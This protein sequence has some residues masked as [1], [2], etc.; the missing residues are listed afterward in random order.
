[1]SDYDVRFK[2][3]VK[4]L[5]DL[6][7]KLRK[8]PGAVGRTLES[9]VKQEARGMAV[10]LARYTRPFGF[11]EKA[12]QRGEKSI[13]RDIYAVFATPAEAYESMTA[14]NGTRDKFWSEITTRKFAKARNT[15]A[16]SNSPMKGL[17]IGRLDPAI[18]RQHRTGPYANVARRRGVKAMIVTSAKSLDI[19]V[20]KVM[21]K[22]GFAKGSWINCAKAIGGRVRGSAQWVSRHKQSPGTAIVRTGD[23]TSVTLVNTLGYIDQVC[24]GEN[25]ERALD[26]AQNRLWRAISE[27]LKAINAKANR[28]ISRR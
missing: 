18:H 23:K 24:S 9:L 20:A 19:Y 25:V 21:K 26:E 27:S 8:H 11:S 10:E 2:V 4:G 14:D 28:T 5:P 3:D 12:K 15:L 13:C 17:A 1:M 7:L 6:A 16:Q 22:V